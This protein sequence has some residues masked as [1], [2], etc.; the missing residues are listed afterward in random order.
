M[1]FNIDIKFPQ[2]EIINDEIKEVDLLIE[3][4]MNHQVQTLEEM[5]QESDDCKAWSQVL[6]A[7]QWER[8]RLKSKH[9]GQM[10]Q[11]VLNELN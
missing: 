1:N 10:V 6:T 11:K 2:E 5:S 7:L 4:L 8:R 3:L 9:L